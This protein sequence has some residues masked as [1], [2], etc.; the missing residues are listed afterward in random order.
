MDPWF[1]PTPNVS[2]RNQL[3][4][5]IFFVLAYRKTTYAREQK[6]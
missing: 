3:S 1:S 5:S 4:L 6:Q 2:A